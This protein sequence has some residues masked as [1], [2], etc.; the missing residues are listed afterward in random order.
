MQSD[1][2]LKFPVMAVNNAHSKY[3]LTI[4]MAQAR[5]SLKVLYLQQ[6]LSLRV[7]I[8]SLQGTAGVE[9]DWLTG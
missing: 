5:A 6:T 2:K 3:L 1:G 4:D 9:K 7:K 8:L